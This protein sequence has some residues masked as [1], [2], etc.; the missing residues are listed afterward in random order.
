[1]S[2]EA[3]QNSSCPKKQELKK[4]TA[5]VLLA[6]SWACAACSLL[7]AGFSDWPLELFSHFKL[8]YTLVLLTGLILYFPF[9]SRHLRD[10]KPH[11][12]EFLIIFACLFPS[13]LPIVQLYLPSDVK[14]AEA[15]SHQK[16]K[17]IQINV[18]GFNKSYDK[19]LQYINSEAPDIVS[20]EE[21]SFGWEKEMSNKL[22]DY[23]YHA[24][25]PSDEGNFGIGVYSKIQ[26]ASKPELLISAELPASWLIGFMFENQPLT[27]VFTHPP[28]PIDNSLIAVRDRELN[29]F[30]KIRKEHG[31]TFIVAGDLNSTPWTPVYQKLCKDADLIDSQQS[32]GLQPS[33]PVQILPLRIPIDHFLISKDL[34]VIERKIG[35]HVGSD[36][37]PVCITLRRKDE[38]Q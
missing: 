23:P 29:G 4:Q 18:N 24:C 12:A 19:A 37:F 27:I 34:C 8:Q 21:F 33:W 36:H 3:N 26:P 20:F 1:M 32:S 5:L 9:V 10:G 22:K 31:K 25:Y 11:L 2:S 38:M 16:L 28:P 35:P 7:G 14:S 13:A 30:A 15:G 17:L 6:G